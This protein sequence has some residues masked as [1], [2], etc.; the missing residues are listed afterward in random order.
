M[1]GGIEAERHHQRPRRKRADG[2]FRLADRL[3]IVVI[4]RALRQRNV[5]IG[6]EAGA[7][8]ALMRISPHERIEEGGI[9][10]D[11]NGEHVGPFVEDALRAVAV[12]HVDIEDRDALVL[13]PK[14]SR[15]HRAVVEKAEYAARSLKA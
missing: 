3:Y 13:Q 5:Q 7:G 2:F 11:R 1:L 9:G 15:R 10:M 6:A 12:M 8:A 14:L 4:P